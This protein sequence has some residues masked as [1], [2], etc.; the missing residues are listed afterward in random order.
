L[1]FVERARS[2]AARK[3][4]LM[5][6]PAQEHVGV[7]CINRW[8]AR[9][10]P[11]RYGDSRPVAVAITDAPACF[12]C[13]KKG[14]IR[15]CPTATGR[16]IPYRPNDANDL[17]AASTML[18]CE[19][20]SC[21][22]YSTS[23]RNQRSDDRSRCSFKYPLSLS[24]E[25]DEERVIRD[26]ARTVLAVDDQ[27]RV[28]LSACHAHWR[29]RR[30]IDLWIAFTLKN[31]PRSAMTASMSNV[32]YHVASRSSVANRRIERRYCPGGGQGDA[33]LLASV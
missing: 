17:R 12:T 23:W 26:D 24:F 14:S 16:S 29:K 8:P 28:R 31:P 2:N 21:A 6:L 5:E 27:L 11:R 10:L 15:L 33:L 22:R 4:H 32:A 7:A 19:R 25:R 9:P 13:K 20:S 18:N 30:R 1:L 3:V